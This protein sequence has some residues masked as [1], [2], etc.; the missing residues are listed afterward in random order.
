MN[1]DFV[2]VGVSGFEADFSTAQP[3]VRLW[4]ASVSMTIF[5]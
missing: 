3:M 5:L 1:Y 2:A 4:A